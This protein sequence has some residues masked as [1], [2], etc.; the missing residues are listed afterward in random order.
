MTGVWVNAAAAFAGGCIGVLLKKGISKR[1]EQAA[2]SMVGLSVVIIGLNG[3]IASMF[4]ADPATGALR[5]SGAL[6]LLVS[7][8]AGAV[9]GEL[10]RLEDHINRFGDRIEKRL[11]SEGFSKGFISASLIFSVGA[12]SVVGSLNQG[13]RGDSGV[14]L[15]KRAL[16]FVTAVILGSTLGAGVPFAGITL[17]IYQG[18]MALAAGWLSAMVTDGLLGLICMGG[19]CIVICIGTNFL[20]VTKISTANLLPA[21]LGPVI[22]NLVINV[23]I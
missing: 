21:L 23:K 14:L 20:G 1:V 8:V 7:L 6:V 17:L 22:Y 12:M 2:L 11:G 10:W 9:I 18:A 13:L 5:D 15:V 19:Y 4:K 3:V 16:D